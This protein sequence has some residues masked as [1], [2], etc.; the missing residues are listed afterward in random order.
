MVE[1]DLTEVVKKK[2][3]QSGDLDHLRSQ[4]RHC[5]FHSLHSTAGNTKSLP[6]KCSKP[7]S[8][9]LIDELIIE[10]L[11]YHDNLHEISDLVAGDIVRDDGSTALL[12]NDRKDPRRSKREIPHLYKLI[13]FLN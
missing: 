9:S 6:T 11:R 13:R 4:L 5:V 7:K 1:M 2:L 3:E 10:Y 12:E 8:N